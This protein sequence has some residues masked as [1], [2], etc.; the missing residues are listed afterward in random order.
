KIADLVR[1]KKIEGISDLRDESDRKGIRVVVDVKRGEN[2]TVILNR[3]YKLTQLQERYGISLLAIHNNQPKVFN[4][5]DMLWAFVEHRRD[6]VVRRTIF[7]LRKAEA[8]AHILEGLKIAVENLDDVVA[9]IRASKSPVEAK[10][11]L[12]QKFSFS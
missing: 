3:L 11:G 9:L 2:S 4:L 12:M 6:V 1:N 5:R 10:N 7:E 8:R